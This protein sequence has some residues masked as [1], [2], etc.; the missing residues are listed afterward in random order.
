GAMLEALLTSSPLP[1]HSRLLNLA[2]LSSVLGQ[3]DVVVSS[4]NLGGPLPVAG[5]TRPIYILSEE[6]SLQRAKNQG[7]FSY[8]HF[9]PPQTVQDGVLLTL[10]IRIAQGDPLRPTLGL[11]GIQVT[12]HQV[13]TGW[14]AAEQ[15]AEFAA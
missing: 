8:L 10:Q 15:I 9:Q 3:P 5:V 6:D 4:D 12:F 11:S 13:G 2:D 1:G 14:Q 7:D